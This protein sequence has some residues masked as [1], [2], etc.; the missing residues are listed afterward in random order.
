MPVTVDSRRS[1]PPEPAREPGPRY[2]NR[3]SAASEEFLRAWAREEAAERPNREAAKRLVHHR[4][5][6][7]RALMGLGLF[8]L[9]LTTLGT[10]VFYLVGENI[11]ENV[12]RV[13]DVFGPID[14]A[15]RPAEN[16]SLTFLLVGTDSRSVD[17]AAETD[18]DT[19]AAHSDVL[20]IARL[21]ADRTVAAVASIPR[22]SWVD[23]PGHGR[24][25]INSAYALG[26]PPL[27]IRTVEDLTQ[28]RIDHFAVID[29][30][31]FEFIVDSVGGIHIDVDT[32]TTS[33][34]VTLRRGRDHLDGREALAY[35]RE[36][37]VADRD[38]DR[39][40]RQQKALRALV[41]QVADRQMLSSPAGTLA[42]L[43]AAS[44]AVSVDDTL[45]NG[46]LRTLASNLQGVDPA[47][48]TFVRAPVAAVGARGPHAPVDLDT[49][50]AA[51]LWSALRSDSV[52]A[53]ADMYP[54]D[55]LDAVKE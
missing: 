20:M 45:S 21:N 8:L 13:P 4:L 55:T 44:R 10:A 51:Q 25:R 49:T 37:G 24:G 53:Y 50:Q 26:G 40:Q 35:V 48:M 31:G 3:A 47:A 9:A 27:L 33:D 5:R 12:K 32:T 29:F 46:G 7:R 11:G 43:D 38:L 30:A 52:A 16:K 36:H 23:I 17:P 14:P 41:T 18:V 15:T 1:S 54:D 39:G 6:R 34:G 42:L 2:A 19:D 22:D 28:I